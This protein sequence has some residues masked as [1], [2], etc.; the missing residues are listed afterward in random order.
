M[1]F[2]CVIAAFLGVGWLMAAKVIRREKVDFLNRE[3][4]GAGREMTMA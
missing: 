1:I 3:K 2:S 4:M